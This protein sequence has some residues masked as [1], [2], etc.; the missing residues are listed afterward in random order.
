[1]KPEELIIDLEEGQES[2]KKPLP[3]ETEPEAEEETEP[4]PELEF[5]VEFEEEPEP[6]TQGMDYTPYVI[7]GAATAALVTI[8]I[9]WKR[10]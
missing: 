8:A 10:K 6:E 2:S 1:M 4:E 5:E 9:W 3:A 7:G